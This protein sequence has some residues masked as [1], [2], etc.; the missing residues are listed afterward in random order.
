MVGP[1]VG[2]EMVQQHPNLVDDDD[3]DDDDDDISPYTRV[4]H[5]LAHHNCLL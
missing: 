1:D 4:Q 2:A 5:V 3:D